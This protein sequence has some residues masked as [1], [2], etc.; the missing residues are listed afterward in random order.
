MVFGALTQGQVDVYVDYAGTLW[1]NEMKRRDNPPRRRMIAGVT[2]WAGAQR[3]VTVLGPLGFENAYAL[4]MPG[5]VARA[6]HI[7]SIADL[8]G[9]A[10]GLTLG[11]DLEFLDRPEWATIRR[12]YDL[13][14]AATR[15]F[16][17]TFMYDALKSRDADVI[18][19]FSS[20]GRIAADG[21]VVLADPKGAIPSYD[22]LL[23]VGGRVA[24]DPRLVAA[25][26]PIIGAVPVDTMR[27]A[28]LMVDRTA[29]KASPDEAARWLEAAIGR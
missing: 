3:G 9:A 7:A 10:P 22:A 8:T 5:A 1:A 20:D 14:F 6:K 16:N 12:S 18:S 17:P 27:R 21:L 23:L 26:Q 4:A 11:A 29:N 28:N 15:T 2:G 24:H 13:R 19:A 25:L